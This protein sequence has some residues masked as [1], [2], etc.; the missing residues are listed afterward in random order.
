MKSVGREVVKEVIMQAR[1]K[2]DINIHPFV[3]IVLR[4]CLN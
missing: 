1:A 2:G 4:N 3:T